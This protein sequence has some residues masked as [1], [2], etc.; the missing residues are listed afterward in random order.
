MNDVI[1]FSTLK[2]RKPDMD[3]LTAEQ[4]ERL[5]EM[6]EAHGGDDETLPVRTAF[7]VL[8]DTDGNVQ[9]TPDLDVQVERQ[10]LPSADEVYGIAAV[11]QKD[12][13]AQESAALT[14]NSLM[15]MG[16]AMRQQT[17]NQQ[18]RSQLKL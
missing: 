3:D 5:G 8:V 2:D 12:I 7:L 16:S 6:A 9:V 17:E 10:H 1:D 11:V 14:Q 15:Q 4:Q 18:L 13:A